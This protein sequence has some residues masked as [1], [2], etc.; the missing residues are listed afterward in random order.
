MKALVLK[1]KNSLAIMDMSF[2]ETAARM[3]CG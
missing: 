3:T 2:N 1:E